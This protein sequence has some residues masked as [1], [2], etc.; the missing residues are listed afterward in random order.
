MN[1][2]IGFITGV[3]CYWL[4]RIP[5]QSILSH[6]KNREIKVP[7]HPRSLPSKELSLYIQ[8]HDYD[9]KMDNIYSAAIIGNNLTVTLKDGKKYQLKINDYEQLFLY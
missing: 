7:S 1:I 3:V 8:N 4:V 5:A 2:A 6:N 9:Y